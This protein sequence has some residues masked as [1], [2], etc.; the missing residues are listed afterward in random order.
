MVTYYVDFYS[1]EFMEEK[2][3]FRVVENNIA[4]V[5][6]P[7]A[8]LEKVSEDSLIYK[9]EVAQEKSTKATVVAVGPGRMNDV[10]GELVP[11]EVSVGDKIIY[12]AHEGTSVKV[13]GKDYL[14]LRERDILVIL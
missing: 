6:D 3:P 13:N 1:G 14:I 7:D 9:P 2:A 5:V 8:G 4:V 12:R 11:M 10:K